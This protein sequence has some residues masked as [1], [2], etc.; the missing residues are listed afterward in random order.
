MK[1][2]LMTLLLLPTLL[3]AM[4]TP[5]RI[6]VASSAPP[7]VIRSNYNQFYGFDIA[8]MD[9]ICS[10]LARPCQYIPMNINEI[11][12]AITNQNVDL[13]VS[14]IVITPNRAKIVLFSRPYM[15]SEGQF[16]GSITRNQDTFNMK[17][18]DNQKIGVVQGSAYA[19]QVY[20][21]NIKQPQVIH[22]QSADQLIAALESGNIDAGFLDKYTAHYWQNNSSQRLQT[23]GKTFSVGYGLG[24]VTNRANVE[25]IHAVNQALLLYESSSDFKNNFNLY[26]G[27]F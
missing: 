20:S 11:L 26:L 25:L 13:A 17:D 8:M 5:L 4:N 1:T 22:Y 7:F 21:M 9:Y 24:I 23:L 10:S 2:L 27:G 16:I 18:L 6:A 14:S 3:F 19:T 12:A 15:L